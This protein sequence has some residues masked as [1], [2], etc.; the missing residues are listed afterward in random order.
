MFLLFPGCTNSVGLDLTLC[1]GISI[2]VQD[3][4]MYS[5]PV[6]T[7]YLEILDISTDMEQKESYGSAQ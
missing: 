1:K 6:C 4:H 7:E 3:F 5:H 2:F